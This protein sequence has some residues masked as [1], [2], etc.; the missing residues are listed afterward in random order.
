MKRLFLIGL[1]A[2]I[3]VIASAQNSFNMYKS[4]VLTN[5]DTIIYEIDF[6]GLLNERYSMATSIVADSISGT[7][8]VAAAVLQICLSPTVAD[9]HT[10]RTY[11]ITKSA[12]QLK[13]FQTD[14]IQA[15][16]VRWYFLSSGTQVTNV[17]FGAH[18][19]KL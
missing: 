10:V 12:T 16:R 7:N 15:V 3:T 2:V 8:R 17:K 19:T 6:K 14:T 9:W 11:T 13:S 1:F 5:A 4:D 18:F